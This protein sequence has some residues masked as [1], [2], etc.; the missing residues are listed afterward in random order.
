[1]AAARLAVEAVEP[2][3]RELAV[4]IEIIYE[5]VVFLVDKKVGHRIHE[6]N[7]DDRYCDN[8]FFHLP[9]APNIREYL[10]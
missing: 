4:L 10:I 6:D 1:M 7:Q 3:A 2:P 8:N 9:R 5:I